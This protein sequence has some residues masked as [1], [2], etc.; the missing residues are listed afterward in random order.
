[1]GLMKDIRY[2]NVERTLLELTFGFVILE[3]RDC[4]ENLLSRDEFGDTY[5]HVFIQYD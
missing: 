4:S 1:M 3:L 5:E 2:E